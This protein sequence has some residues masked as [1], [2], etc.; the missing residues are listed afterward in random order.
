M[1]AAE[2]VIRPQEPKEYG[3][4]RGIEDTESDRLV[5]FAHQIAST[6]GLIT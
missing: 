5:C 6:C 4:F 2:P 3:T 1:T